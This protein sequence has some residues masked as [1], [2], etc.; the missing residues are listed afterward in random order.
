MKTDLDSVGP[1]TREE[2]ISEKQRRTREIMRE[3][4]ARRG[5]M[6]CRDCDWYAAANCLQPLVSNLSIDTEGN[7]VRDVVLTKTARRRDD[8]CGVEADLF[9]PIPAWK[10]RADARYR[11]FVR[12]SR[13]LA[14]LLCL[15]IVGGG[16]GWLIATFG[17]GKL[18]GA[19]AIIVFGMIL[20][21]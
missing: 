2:A 3:A 17:I 13:I 4:D 12:S 19:V 14:V 8:L 15:L 6:Q 11:F 1:L 10:R 16:V 20:L 21:S 18:I 5:R 7:E 9:V